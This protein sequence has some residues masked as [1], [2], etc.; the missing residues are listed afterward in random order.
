MGPRGGLHASN[1]AL[2]FCTFELRLCFE[3]RSYTV[4]ALG[5]DRS[6]DVG[7]YASMLLRRRVDR[8]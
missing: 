1:A 8:F 5:D 7:A 3:E 2:L 6:G 4:G